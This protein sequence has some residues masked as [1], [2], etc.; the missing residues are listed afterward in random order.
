MK[1]VKRYEV[2][3]STGHCW[4]EG[5]EK[6]NNRGGDRKRGTIEEGIGKEEQ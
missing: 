1:R 3:N 4:Q 6:R 5:I 2:G